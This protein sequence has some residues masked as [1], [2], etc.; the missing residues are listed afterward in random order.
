MPVKSVRLVLLCVAVTLASLVGLASPASAAT[1]NVGPGESIQAAVDA[2]QP[3]DTIVV[4]AGTY[5]ESVVIREDDLTILGADAS[6][7]GTVL[8]PPASP[9][10][11][12]CQ[13][14]DGT[15]SGFCILGELPGEDEPF[16]PGGPVVLNTHI[17]GFLIR[18]F[19]SSGLFAF[20]ARF[21]RFSN[22]VL[23]DNDE[24]GLY[25]N[26]SQGTRINNVLASGS[27]EAGLY[28]GDTANSATGIADSNAFENGTGIFIRDASQ[29]LI[30]NVTVSDNCTGV[31]FLNTGLPNGVNRWTLRNSTVSENNAACAATAESPPTS[32]I[33]IA[34]L[35]TRDVTIIDNRVNRN[36]R[37]GPSVFSGGIMLAS[38]KD[39]GGSN[40][41]RNRIE[42]NLAKRNR[43]ADLI[44]D[45]TGSDN[46]FVNNDCNRSA[47][48]GLCT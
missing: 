24:Y 9:P 28:V 29:G 44:W 3:G 33:G 17:D 48:K 6:P 19:S 37:S 36:Q 43:P 18:G 13:G 47:P 31:V 46:R 22:L 5:H 7:F 45:G 11:N 21:S 23:E 38:S 40:P 41:I 32:G 30:D 26:D 12:L 8:E 25:V 15:F 34:L 4:A 27:D 35:G 20:H 2:A 10:N 42:T 39:S 14:D 16:E 1:I